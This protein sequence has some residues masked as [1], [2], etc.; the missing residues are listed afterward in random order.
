MPGGLRQPAIR[1]HDDCQSD[2]VAS[3]NRRADRRPNQRADTDDSS[4][5][6]TDFNANAHTQSVD[7]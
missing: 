1:N 3:A 7:H 4:N 5:T 2:C 6:D